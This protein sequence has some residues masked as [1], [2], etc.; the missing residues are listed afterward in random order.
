MARI[1]FDRIRHAYMADPKTEADYALKELSMTW[2][3]GGAY[4]LLGPS[5]CG[6]TTLLNI[7][8][9]LLHPSGGSIRFDGK[10][11]TTLST[12]AR[13]I[14]QVFQ[15]PVI[16]DTMTV[17][18]NLA[19]PLKNRGVA[20]DEISRRVDETL[21]IIDL[22]EKADRRA[23]RLTA[24]EKQKISL[25]RGLV[26]SDVNAILFDEPLTVI[27]PH[28]K[29]QLRSKLKELH[30][31]FAF[32][33][34]YVTHDQTEALTFADKVVVMYE[35]EVVQTGTP[36]ELFRKPKH[37]FVGYFIGSP[38]M[39]VLPCKVSG[40]TASIGGNKVRLPVGAPKDAKSLEVG[41]RPEFIT[42]TG[43]RTGIPVSINRV[44]DIGRFRIVHADLAGKEIAATL[45]EG[46]EIPAEPRAVFDP[47]NVNLYADSW[48]VEAKG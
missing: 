32:T 17:R 1:E 19:F 46:S 26:R 8:S 41:I 45:P 9:G 15:F 25:G 5:G 28:M 10:D 11:V 29:W 6:K 18:E 37:T 40:K 35:G 30:Q 14:A 31:R 48:L 16:Y 43:G 27:D 12:E 36:D 21:R 3:D 2:E 22:E 34:I 47:A 4:A 13:N 38:G 33:M 20:R 23:R 42:L 7:I 39:N 44:E 24:D